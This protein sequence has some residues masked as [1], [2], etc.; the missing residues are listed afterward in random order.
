MSWLSAS[1][2]M[3]FD[4]LAYRTLYSRFYL[5]SNFIALWLIGKGF[6][7]VEVPVLS[8]LLTRNDCK[9]IE[10]NALGLFGK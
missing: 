4:T 9:A 8:A 6:W 3:R 2:H 1:N 5:F 7:R 10:C